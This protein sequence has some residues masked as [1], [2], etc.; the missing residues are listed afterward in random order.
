MTVES[1]LSPV[2]AVLDP[3]VF[4]ATFCRSGDDGKHVHLEMLRN[5]F[6]R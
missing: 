3:Q 6:S 5:G 1:F 2:A 4:L